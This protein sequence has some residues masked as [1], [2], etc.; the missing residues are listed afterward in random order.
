MNDFTIGKV[1]A[2][3]GLATSAIRYYESEGV[4]PRPPRT[5][6]RRMYNDNW[7]KWLGI[8]MLSQEAGFSIGEIREL[9]K[10]FPKNSLPSMSWRKAASEKSKE[11]DEELKRIKKVQSLLKMMSSCDCSSLEDCGEAALRHMCPDS[12]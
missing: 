9:V 8:V 6:G 2:R 4:V 10:Q 12:H 11:L 3:T 1:A 7:M 5:N